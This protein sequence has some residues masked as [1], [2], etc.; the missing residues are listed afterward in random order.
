M[1]RKIARW[2]YEATTGISPGSTILLAVLLV[3]L[4][5][6]PVINL[7]E[8]SAAQQTRLEPDQLPAPALVVVEWAECTAPPVKQ[9]GL[10]VNCAGLELYR[11]RLPDGTIRGPFIAVP[12]PAGWNADPSKW[13]WRPL[14]P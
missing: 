12:A 1:P 5:L 7:V 13:T 11:F 8:E 3:V 6:A 9:P 2:W 14:R 10:E 4:P